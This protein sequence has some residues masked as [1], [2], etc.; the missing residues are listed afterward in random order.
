MLINP[1]SCSSCDVG[2]KTQSGLLLHISLFHGRESILNL[3][4]MQVSIV[5]IKLN[6]NSFVLTEVLPIQELTST[7][8]A[9]VFIAPDPVTCYYCYKTFRQRAGS[10]HA[11]EK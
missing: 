4:G 9:S 6:S 8:V 2:I 7:N 5:G 11:F 3:Q 1:A 10:D